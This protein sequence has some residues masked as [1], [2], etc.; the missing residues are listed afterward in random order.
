MSVNLA[1]FTGAK[2]E[3]LT[4]VTSGTFR[5]NNPSIQFGVVFFK[6]ANLHR[7]HDC[8]LGG[9]FLAQFQLDV[10]ISSRCIRHVQSGAIIQERSVGEKWKLLISAVPNE[11]QFLDDQHNM[12]RQEESF[13]S[14]VKDLFPGDTPAVEDGEY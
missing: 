8:I 11:I 9:P 7:N 5:F 4:H 2:P 14:D 13:V 10:S 3:K 6:L 1:I 12:L